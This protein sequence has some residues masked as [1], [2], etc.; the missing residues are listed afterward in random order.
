[1]NKRE[2][3]LPDFERGVRCVMFGHPEVTITEHSGDPWVD[4]LRSYR[5]LKGFNQNAPDV[6]VDIVV[7]GNEAWIGVFSRS[8]VLG[9]YYCRDEDGEHIYTTGND[10][11]H[12][13]VLSC[14]GETCGFYDFAGETLLF[15]IISSRLRRFAAA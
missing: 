13:G 1:M 4:V 5:R 14:F 15:S 12:Q 9:L 6:H 10:H 3:K 2:G 8:Q 11:E 7:T